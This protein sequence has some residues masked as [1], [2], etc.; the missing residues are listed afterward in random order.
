MIEIV[1]E[2]LTPDDVAMILSDF[3]TD[4]ELSEC[5]DCD[6]DTCPL[7]ILMTLEVGNEESEMTICEMLKGISFILNEEV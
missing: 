6:C 2:K 4:G 3:M 7:G 1:K 5:V